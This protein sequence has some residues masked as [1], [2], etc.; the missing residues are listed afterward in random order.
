MTSNPRPREMSHFGP[1]I[2]VA[3][4]DD[5]D[6]VRAKQLEMLQIDI[7]YS[8]EWVT[9]MQ[10][11]VDE[12]L[13]D[14]DFTLHRMSA[15]HE[16]ERRR[17]GAQ[18]RLHYKYDPIKRKRHLAERDVKR[19]LEQAREVLARKRAELQAAVDAASPGVTE[20]AGEMPPRKP[21]QPVESERSRTASTNTPPPRLS[22]PHFADLDPQ[23]RGMIESDI[24]GI[25]LATASN[26]D[27]LS[28]YLAHGT[29]EESAQYY[30][31]LINGTIKP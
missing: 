18:K 15:L 5:P 27:I 28:A 9:T 31:G 6:R 20:L 24:P 19:T 14:K 12:G 7:D 16:W 10:K 26:D 11:L 8:T 25:D 4:A 3:W 29:P 22:R 13:K 21:R 17:K 23:L 30:L 2:D 1:E